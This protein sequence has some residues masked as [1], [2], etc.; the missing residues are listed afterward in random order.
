MK[1]NT[2]NAALRII[3]GHLLRAAARGDAAALR[4][5]LLVY[6]ALVNAAKQKKEAQPCL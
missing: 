4:N 3:G 1:G 2:D 5:H 6:E